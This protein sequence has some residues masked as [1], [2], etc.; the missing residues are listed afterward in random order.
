MVGES[1]PGDAVVVEGPQ[2]APNITIRTIAPALCTDKPVFNNPRR[3]LKN[4]CK[5]SLLASFVFSNMDDPS[6]N[7]GFSNAYRC[8]KSILLLTN[9]IGNRTP[10][11]IPRYRTY[12]LGTCGT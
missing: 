6:I 1:E 7:H 10:M 4:V 12:V 9:L 8:W 11:I 2:P 3:V 5:D